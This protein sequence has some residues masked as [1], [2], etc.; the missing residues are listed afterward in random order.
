MLSKLDKMD[1]MVVH[2]AVIVVMCFALLNPMGI[3]IIPSA[4]TQ[5]VYDLVES[6]PSG[7]IVFLGMDYS[8]AGVPEMEPSVISMVRQ[9]WAK[10]LRF[11]AVGVDSQMAGDLA[12][13]AFSQVMPEFPDK[14]YGVDWINIGYKPGYEVL[15]E[16]MLVSIDEACMGTDA[17]GSSLSAFPI[18][19]DF[20]TIKDAS[21]LTTFYTGETPSK[22]VKHIVQ[23]YNIPLVVSTGTGGV[24]TVMPLVASGQVASVLVGMKGA[25]EYEALVKKPGSATRGLDAQSLVHLLV[26]LFIILGNVGYYS[27]RKTKTA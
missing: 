11:V 3:A 26:V 12:D 8:S 23:P 17:N 4:D 27:S 2:A 20:V 22:Y 19:T 18:M 10:G 7:S 16:K 13:Q 6:L 5:E 14:T 1:S 25:A 21:L 9:G 24:P 15:M